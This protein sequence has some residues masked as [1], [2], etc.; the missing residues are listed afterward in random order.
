MGPGE[1]RTMSTG[2]VNQIGRKIM[3]RT[4]ATIMS[5]ALLP[6]SYAVIEF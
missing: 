6:V 1:L 4:E 3:A 2:T 5:S